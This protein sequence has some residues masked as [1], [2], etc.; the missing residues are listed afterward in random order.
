MQIVPFISKSLKNNILF[1]ITN[2]ESYFSNILGS[3]A[4]GSR[5][6]CFIRPPYNQGH[7]STSK[8]KFLL[9]PRLTCAIQSITPNFSCAFP[10][11]LFNG[12]CHSMSGTD[13]LL[14]EQLIQNSYP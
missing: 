1:R 6:G 4:V 2:A 5:A 3:R 13:T 14:L 9:T 10:R 8:N 12:D 7:F 11:Q